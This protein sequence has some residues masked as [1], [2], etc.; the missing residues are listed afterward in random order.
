MEHG[1]EG[2]ERGRKGMTVRGRSGAEPLV[3]ILSALHPR[4]NPNF[5][6]RSYLVGLRADALVHPSV[7]PSVVHPWLNDS[8][9]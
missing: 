8:P 1:W 5:F 3:S 2:D 7:F 6:T 9:E 4:I